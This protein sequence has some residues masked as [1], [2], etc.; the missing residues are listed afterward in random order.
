MDT[1]Q[2]QAIYNPWVLKIYDLWVLGISNRFF[3]RCETKRIEN[4]F[5]QNVS[6]NHADVGVGTGYY[7]KKC[8]LEK[9][10]LLDLNPNSLEMTQNRLLPL[11]A[12]AY[13]V[14]VLKPIKLD[15]E[16]F[17]SMSV[18]YLLHCLPGNLEQ[19]G[20]CFEY[21]RP[22]LNKGAVVF[23]STILNFNHNK[24]GSKLMKIYN[25]KGIFSNL[26]DDKESLKRVLEHYFKEVKIEIVGCVALFKAKV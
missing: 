14:D 20:K 5:L 22:L 6:S 21:L 10:A 13:Q 24:L 4:L 15:C 26:N 8:P 7:L 16:P 18:N 2:G 25:Q 9:I 23:G 17:L 19:K 1:H 12:K 11:K 3:W